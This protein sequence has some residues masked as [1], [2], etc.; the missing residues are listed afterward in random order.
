M[1]VHSVSSAVSDVVGVSAQFVDRPCE[2]ISGKGDG[3]KGGS[4]GGCGGMGNDAWK[5]LNGVQLCCVSAEPTPVGP[6]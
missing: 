6:S 3:G 5:T 4:G 2:L 1:L